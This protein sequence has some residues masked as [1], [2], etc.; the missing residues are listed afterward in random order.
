MSDVATAEAPGRVNLI[1]EHTDYHEGFVL[2]T[3]IPQR[4]RVTVRRRPDVRATVTSAAY[5]GD[6][7]SYDVGGERPGRGW[8]D[9]VQ[10]VTAILRR[11]GVDVPGFE[12][13]IES[14]VPV[15]A[16]LSS[17]AA[18]TVSLLRGLRLLL[19]VRLDDRELARLAQQAETDFVG[20]PV[21][22]MDQ[23]VCSLGLPGTALFLDTRT[24]D[25]QHVPIPASMPLLVIDSGV[26]HRHAS[27]GYRQR[28]RESFDAAAA[29][30]VALLRDVGIDALPRIDALPQPLARRG[31]H[32]VT[33]NARVIAAVDALHRDDAVALGQLFDLSH[34]SL[35]DDYQVSDPDVDLLVEL[36][37][38]DPA[39]YGA[40]MTGGGFGGAVVVL[41][42]SVTPGKDV[43]G[44][45]CTAYHDRTG[46]M[47]RVLV[48]MESSSLHG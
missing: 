7:A 18:L 43:A 5:A 11:H 17:S 37:Q 14:D 46:R 21:G 28:R 22:I 33:E 32:V 48:P 47:A 25:Y 39:V 13:H 35:R 23:M 26:E 44:R 2:P 31:R 12:L 30:G 4:T 40:R 20:A 34:A 15:G 42:S 19:A 8:L 1:G 45:I 10:G 38:H 36:A 24:L 29:L 9:Y 6:L 41:T 27:G 16:G 3:V